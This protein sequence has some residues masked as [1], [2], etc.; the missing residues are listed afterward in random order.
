MSITKPEL[1]KYT[2]PRVGKKQWSPFQI[3]KRISFISHSGIFVFYFTWF[4]F[5]NLHIL[6]LMA[7]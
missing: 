6:P 5:P 7:L 1:V 3:W 2:I 4:D